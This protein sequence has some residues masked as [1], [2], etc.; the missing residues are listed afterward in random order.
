MHRLGSNW[1]YSPK[2]KRAHLCFTPD[3]DWV[4]DFTHEK[5]YPVEN[6]ATWQM[7]IVSHDGAAFE[8]RGSSAAPG[9]L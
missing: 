8:A 1:W 4:I 9:F 5:Q 6:Q 2:V 7:T 3:D